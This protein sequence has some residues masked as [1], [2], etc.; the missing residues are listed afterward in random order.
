MTP[1]VPPLPTIWNLPFQP[2]LGIHTSNW[3]AG[4][5]TPTTRQIGAAI[6]PTGFGFTPAGSISVSVIVVS[7]M[8]SLVLRSAQAMGFAASDGIATS[9]PDTATAEKNAQSGTHSRFVC[10]KLG[11]IV[12]SSVSVVMLVIVMA[13]VMPVA[14]VIV[15]LAALG[16]LEAPAGL[17]LVLDDAVHARVCA[18]LDVAAAVP[19]RE[20][21]RIAA[22]VVDRR[23]RIRAHRPRA[24]RRVLRHDRVGRRAGLDPV[25]HRVEQR[26]RLRTRAAA[27]MRHARREEKAEPGLHALEAVIA[28]RRLAVV[29]DRLAPRDE[30]VRAAVP[31]QDLRA[32]LLRAAQIGADDVAVGRNHA[33][34][35]LGLV[36]EQR[37]RLGREIEIRVAVRPRED[38]EAAAGAAEGR[39]VGHAG[40]RAAPEREPDAQA[41]IVARPVPD[42]V[43]RLGFLR[44]KAVRRGRTEPTADVVRRIVGARTRIA[45]DAVGQ[46]V[47]R[48][49]SDHSG[50]VRRDHLRLTQRA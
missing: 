35:E 7:A 3:T 40:V 25:H 17:V 33:R 29:V 8:L 13:F 19:A 6:V 47:L 50:S 5:V 45:E 18:R 20:K 43:Y 28:L 2:S 22:A 11:F 48:V 16:V 24:E 23:L 46:A 30:L 31:H 37:E 38:A 39:R 42:P 26:L 15:A 36:V 4:V 32:A 9:A 12:F 34:R 21:L 1:A 14:I 41:V 27:A 49:A 44:R 10:C